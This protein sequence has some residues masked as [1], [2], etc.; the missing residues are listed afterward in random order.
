MNVTAIPKKFILLVIRFYQ[1]TL[2]PDHG[3]LKAK[4]PYGYCRY[5]P[6]CS[7]YGYESIQRHGLIKGI[8]YTVLRI[9]RCVPWKSSKVDLVPEK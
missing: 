3:L 8:V 9:S 7:A 5:Y 6:S 2:S 4:F 1:K